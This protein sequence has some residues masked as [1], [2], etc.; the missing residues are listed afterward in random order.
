MAKF[1]VGDRIRKTDN[2]AFSNG[3]M[4]VTVGKWRGAFEQRPYQVWLKEPDSWMSE[5]NLELAVDNPFIK[6][7]TTTKLNRGYIMRQLPSGHDF[8][9]SGGVISATLVLKD[10]T[11][12]LDN[13]DIP[14][15]IEHLQN[16]YDAVQAEKDNS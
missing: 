4:V 14:T 6:T 15:F 2:T 8:T 16:F 13:D 1:K 11:I 5:S 10:K 9:I 12:S 3:M 7:V